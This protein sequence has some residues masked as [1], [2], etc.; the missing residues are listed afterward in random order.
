ML[1]SSEGL[2][3][4]TDTCHQFTAFGQ[5]R[6]YSLEGHSPLPGSIQSF[7]HRAVCVATGRF[8]NFV[9][10]ALRNR[11]R[12]IKCPGQ[13]RGIVLGRRARAVG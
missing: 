11:H 1:E 6:P 9:V 13:R 7:P 3:I 8:L 12:R 4:T 10:F 2:H 5:L